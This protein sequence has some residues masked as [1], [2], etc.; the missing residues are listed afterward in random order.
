VARKRKKAR[1]TLFKGV[2]GFTVLATERLR[3]IPEDS[4]LPMYRMKLPFNIPKQSDAYAMASAKLLDRIFL[5][6]PTDSLIW[7][8]ELT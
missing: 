6:S 4:Y 2:L 8:M 3:Y 1:Y 5:R 7:V